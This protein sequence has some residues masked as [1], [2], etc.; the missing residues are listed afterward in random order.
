MASTLTTQG[1]AETV[2]LLLNSSGALQPKYLAFGVGS[3]ISSPSDQALFQETGTRV[4][5]TITQTTTT[6]SGDTYQLVATFTAVSGTTLT[7]LGIFNN[8][9]SPTQGYL[10]SQVSSSSQTNLSIS[11]YSSWPTNY[12]YNV[13]V[14]TEVMTVV[15]G[16]GSTTL[17]VNRGANGSTVLSSIPT[18]TAVTQCSGLLFAKTDFGGLPLSAGDSIQFTIGIQYQ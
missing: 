13:Q 10:I 2:S 11:N 6:T 17:Y 12:P 1:R 4:L 16:N 7:N 15:S 14:S 9:T 5:G 8:P 3:G 18:L